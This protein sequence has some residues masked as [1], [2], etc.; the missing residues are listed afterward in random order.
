MGTQPLPPSTFELALTVAALLP[1]LQARAAKAARKAFS[2]T[3]AAITRPCQPPA[4]QGSTQHSPKGP[5]AAA[6]GVQPQQQQ[7]G[8]AGSEQRQGWDKRGIAKQQQQQQSSQRGG[9]E[10]GGCRAHSGRIVHAL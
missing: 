7:R 8:V 10:G 4:R 9:W 5:A 3:A 6:T 2:A 1:S